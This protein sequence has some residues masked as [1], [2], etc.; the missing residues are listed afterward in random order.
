M[1]LETLDKIV[2]SSF[3]VDI[4]SKS[5]HIDIVMARAIFYDLAY[6]KFKISSLSRI[7]KYVGKHHTT[8]LHSLNNLL[9]I[10]PKCYKYHDNVYKD[11]LR[12][13]FVYDDKDFDE[14]DYTKLEKLR[15]QYNDLLEKYNNACN[16]DD[17]SDRSQLI[18]SIRRLPEDKVPIL[19]L[20]VDAILK[21]I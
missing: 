14:T 19:K 9:P 8:V 17:D 11:I 3:D 12:R 6:N 18:S 15:I 10:I 7:G 4:K 16:G 2:S 21:M 13:I 1:T 5:R 20:R